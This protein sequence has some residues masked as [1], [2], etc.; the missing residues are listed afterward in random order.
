MYQAELIEHVIT[1]LDGSLVD[2]E[3]YCHPVIYGDKKAVQSVFRDITKRKEAE[4]NHKQLLR[5]INEVSASIVTCI[6]RDFHSSS[7]WLD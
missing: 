3:L 4:R 7:D 1:K 6:G 5:E 2:V